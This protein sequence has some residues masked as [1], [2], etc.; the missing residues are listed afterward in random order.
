M[1]CVWCGVRVNGL[2]GRSPGDR[3]GS[4]EGKGKKKEEELINKACEFIPPTPTRPRLAAHCSMLR[5]TAFLEVCSN[6]SLELE[7]VVNVRATRG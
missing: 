5:D 1:T 2:A 4:R 7:I 6:S 3:L